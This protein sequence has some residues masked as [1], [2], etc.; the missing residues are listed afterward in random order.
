[1]SLL[2]CSTVGHANVQCSQC[3]W[4][5]LGCLGG[6]GRVYRG[7]LRMCETCR[8]STTPNK[9]HQPG[10]VS[11]SFRKHFKKNEPYFYR[12]CL[13]NQH[14]I[15]VRQSCNGLF[16]SVRFKCPRDRCR[17]PVAVRICEPQCTTS[18]SGL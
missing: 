17:A 11:I 9:R 13:L 10:S 15:N 12:K 6:N 8:G 4:N 5:A 7:L 18:L 16:L 3:I 14:G 2:N 1:M